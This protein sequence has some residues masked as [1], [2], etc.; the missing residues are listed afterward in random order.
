MPGPAD[1]H[2]MGGGPELFKTKSLSVDAL[3][4]GQDSKGPARK[5]VV[6]L[7]H[8]IPG[9]SDSAPAGPQG[10]AGWAWPRAAS[11][12]WWPGTWP[13]L[14]AGQGLISARC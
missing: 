10:P 8:S 3:G 11:R 5:M 6:A 13:E 1:G 14:A 7:W 9:G 4:L 12:A 2:G